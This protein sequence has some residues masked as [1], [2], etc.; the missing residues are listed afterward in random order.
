MQNEEEEVGPF[1]GEI[2]GQGNFWSTQV[3]VNL[4]D[5]KLDTGATVTII[6]DSVPWL[7]GHE[8][9]PTT[10]IVRGPG[11]TE[12]S[13]VGT[14]DARLISQDNDF[15]ETVYILK[16]QACSLLSKRACDRLRLVSTVWL[17]S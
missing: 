3:K 11:H 17:I 9:K 5:F 1:Q 6:S 12:W 13:V 10:Q 8:L 16:D 4:T 7:E 15:Q 14:L 2:C